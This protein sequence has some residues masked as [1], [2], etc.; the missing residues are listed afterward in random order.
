[1][2]HFATMNTPITN[3]QLLISSLKAKGLEVLYN[4]KIRGYQGALSDRM[5]D[6][7]GCSKGLGM[8]H[9]LGY[10]WGPGLNGVPAL[11]LE[12]HSDA[13]TYA[14][15]R[16]VI[17]DY[18][19]RKALEQSTANSQRGLAAAKLNVLVAARS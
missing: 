1:M 7:V 19:S 5:Y 6:I 3:K 13:E 14:I 2:S 17:G 16:E 18:L 15:Y 12:F 10:Y 8:A 9:D 11:V 4:Q